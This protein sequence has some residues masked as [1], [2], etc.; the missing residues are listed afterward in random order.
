MRKAGVSRFKEH[1]AKPWLTCNLWESLATVFPIVLQDAWDI[2]PKLHL[3][4]G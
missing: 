1:R 3:Y 4:Q 2:I